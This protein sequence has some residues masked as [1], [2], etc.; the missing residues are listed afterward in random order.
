MGFSPLQQPA[1]VEW[2]GC[3]PE[4][5]SWGLEAA[6]NIVHWQ[7]VWYCTFVGSTTTALLRVD[8]GRVNPSAFSHSLT[9][10]G[11]NSTCIAGRAAVEGACAVLGPN[12]RVHPCAG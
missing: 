6:G 11:P 5:W 1:N 8:V 10:S 9:A 4:H 7:V 2:H 12:L 3:V